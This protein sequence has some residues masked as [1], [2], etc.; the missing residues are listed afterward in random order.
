MHGN[1]NVK[2]IATALQACHISVPSQQTINI[3]SPRLKEY[4]L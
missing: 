4:I 3:G 2:V 1:M